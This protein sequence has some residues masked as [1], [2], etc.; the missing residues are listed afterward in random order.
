M[1]RY[2]R[3]VGFAVLG[4]VV[5]GCASTAVSTERK[6]ED[7]ELSRKGLGGSL[8]VQPGV[9][10]SILTAKNPCGECTIIYTADDDE[11]ITLYFALAMEAKDVHIVGAVGETYAG[12][13]LY[14]DEVA[15]KT[16]PR[17]SCVRLP[18]GVK[19]GQ[20]KFAEVYWEYNCSSGN[21]LSEP[22][23]RD[24]TPEKPYMETM[25]VMKDSSKPACK[26]P[27]SA[28]PNSY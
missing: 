18:A 19:A 15:Y 13:E 9:P 8:P 22:V 7:P 28:G 21:C 23:P 11:T 17:Y 24:G 5:G 25:K 14:A 6:M 16:T 4:L 12:I 27:T 10:T 1:L 2:G 3:W 20:I 26:V